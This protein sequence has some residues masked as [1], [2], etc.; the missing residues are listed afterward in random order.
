VEKLKYMKYNPVLLFKKQGME[1]PK[2]MDNMSDNDFLLC[3]Q[4]EFQ[5]DM[6]QKFGSKAI[7]MDSTHGTNCYNFN[8]ATIVVVDDYGELLAG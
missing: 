8:L 4:T 6:L 1:Q 3:I 2:E 7:C 5:K